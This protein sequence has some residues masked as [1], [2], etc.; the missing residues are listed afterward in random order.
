MDIPLLVG[1]RWPP[2][3]EAREGTQ[4]PINGDT[5]ENKSTDHTLS[6]IDADH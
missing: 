3:L 4:P 6:F 2:V 1:P 5:T